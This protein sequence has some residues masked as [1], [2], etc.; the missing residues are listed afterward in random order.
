[1]KKIIL[2]LILFAFSAQQAGYTQYVV[3]DPTVA[4]LVTQLNMQ[5]NSLSLQ[6]KQ[7]ALAKQKKELEELQKIV[8]S[9]Q[10]FL[11]HA[12]NAK[13]TIVILTSIACLLD[14]ILSLQKLRNQFGFYTCYGNLE[15]EIFQLRISSQIGVMKGLF[16]EVLKTS[17]LEKTTA[18]KNVTRDLYDLKEDMQREKNNLQMDVEAYQAKEIEMQENL[19]S[20]IDSWMFLGGYGKI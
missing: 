18:W 13:Q 11:A 3:S 19:D 1:M 17:G 5:M 6:Q 15:Y 12:N 10:K 20:S 9:H 14:E 8:Q 16:E 7:E 4:T 2:I